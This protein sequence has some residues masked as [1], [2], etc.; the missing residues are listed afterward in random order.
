[1]R[2]PPSAQAIDALEAAFTDAGIDSFEAIRDAAA[3]ED[4]RDLALEHQRQFDR[5]NRT[6][7]DPNEPRAPPFDTEGF[8]VPER[9]MPHDADPRAGRRVQRPHRLA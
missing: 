5:G 3:L 7:P 6:V 4:P 2:G 8:V 9:P 1:M